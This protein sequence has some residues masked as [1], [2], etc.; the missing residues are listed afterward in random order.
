MKYKWNT[1]KKSEKEA[2]VMYKIE[3]ISG[4]GS[5]WAGRPPGSGSKWTLR[6]LQ[7]VGASIFCCLVSES[8]SVLSDS[9]RP[10]GLHPWNS[11]GQNTGVG[12]L[13]L[14]Q[15]IFPT[16]EPN[17][18]LPHCRQILYQL[19]H[20]GNSRILEWVAYPFSSRSSRPRNGTGVSC[21][22][23]GFFTNWAI[24]EE[25]LVSFVPRCLKP[26]GL[27]R[28]T[29][30]KSSTDNG[31]DLRDTGSNLESGKSPGEGNGNPLQYSC[32]E[33]P[34]DRGACQTTV[35][36]VTKS[37]TWLS[38]QAQHTQM[39]VAPSPYRKHWDN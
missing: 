21:I 7:A 15:R 23:G 2:S 20:K 17:P 32:L 28:G 39:P 19:S 27:P 11:P 10:H 5:W 9:L 24:R 3:L 13:S 22:A 14:L 30:V 37:Q 36:R 12:S 26:V 35:Y 16:Q 33:N 18:D 38:M 29:V 8:H 4:M 31:A 6:V 25:H 34:M 1:K